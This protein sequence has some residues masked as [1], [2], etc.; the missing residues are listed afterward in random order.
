MTNGQKGRLTTARWEEKMEQ[1]W[2][3][4][5]GSTEDGGA[6]PAKSLQQQQGGWSQKKFIISGAAFQ[7]S[8]AAN[9]VC[10]CVCVCGVECVCACKV[11][12]QKAV[13]KTKGWVAHSC[14]SQ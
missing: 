10:V 2:R 7:F 11:K 12:M 5:N 6:R 9:Y 14:G 4:R 8:S 3:R 1:G 13:R